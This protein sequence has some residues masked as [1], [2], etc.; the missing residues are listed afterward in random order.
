[1]SRRVLRRRDVERELRNAQ[2]QELDLSGSLLEGDLTG[3]DFEHGFRVD[4]NTKR[5]FKDCAFSRVNCAEAVFVDCG[6]SGTAFQSSN[7]RNCTFEWCDF[8]FSTFRQSTF[9]DATFRNCD[10]YRACF[11]VGNI[12]VGAKLVNVSLDQADLGGADLRWFAIDGGLLQENEGALATFIRHYAPIWEVE[13]PDYLRIFRSVDEH[14][15]RA[16]RARFE[17]AA[18][19]Y[20]NLAGAWASRSY[21][22]DSSR[23]YVAAKRLER[24]NWR[25][26]APL[27]M[28]AGKREPQS[29]DETAGAPPRRTKTLVAAVRSVTTGLR[30]VARYLTSLV[31]DLTSGYGESP[32]RVLGSIS[33]LVAVSAGIYYA[34]G[35]LL[36]EAKRPVRDMVDIVLF[37]LGSLVANPPNRLQPASPAIEVVSVMET[38]V[39]I[40]LVGLLGFVVGNRIRNS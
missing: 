2:G 16:I 31:A 9:E 34:V 22:R 15:E 10:F 40:G 24:R 6:F 26:P 32:M 7:F 30:A 17:T 12:F 28:G 4:S 18:Y 38:L 37:S 3:L 1:V 20:R 5:G 29:P 36:D 19:I 14:V 11:E 23:A 25:E 13:D 21:F 39:G 8:R 27:V 33:L 35:G